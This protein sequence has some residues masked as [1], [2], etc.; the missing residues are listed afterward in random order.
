MRDA[1]DWLDHYRCF[2]EASFER[3]D[4]NLQGLQTRKNP[5]RKRKKSGA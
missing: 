5:R 2:W 4:D 1:A 3:L